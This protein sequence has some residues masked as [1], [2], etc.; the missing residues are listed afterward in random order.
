MLGACTAQ[1]APPSGLSLLVLRDIL[2]EETVIA[3][4]YA[5]SVHIE[6]VLHLDRKAAGIE[7]STEAEHKVLRAC[8]LA[9][10]SLALR[11]LTLPTP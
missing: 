3:T 6:I 4:V 2:S 9:A 5:E 8:F 1:R 7:A 11:L 10:S